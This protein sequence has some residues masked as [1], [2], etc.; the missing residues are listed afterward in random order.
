MAE[1]V[2]DKN[3]II[4]KLPSKEEIQKKRGH[5]VLNDKDNRINTFFYGVLGYDKAV[6][7][8]YF[9]DNKLQHAFHESEY[10]NYDQAEEKM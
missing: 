1:F 9:K 6:C 8:L 4:K 7:T 3:E 2:K 10:D 5:I